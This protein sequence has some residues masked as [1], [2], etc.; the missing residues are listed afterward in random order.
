MNRKLRMSCNGVQNIERDFLKFVMID[1]LLI[2][3][4]ISIHPGIMYRLQISDNTFY[5]LLD[6]P[7]IRNSILLVLSVNYSFASE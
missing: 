1:D 2:S 6:L 5:S 4:F 3:R 7:Q